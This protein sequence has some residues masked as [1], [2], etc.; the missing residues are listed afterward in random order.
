MLFI[1]WREFVCYFFLT[2]FACFSSLLVC[3]DLFSIAELRVVGRSSFHSIWQRY[4]PFILTTRPR[5]DL[6]WTC[7]QNNRR[8]YQGA[9]ITDAAKQEKLNN[10]LE[11]LPVV[12]LERELYQQMVKD[13]KETKLHDETLAPHKP[14]SRPGR[15]HY[16][17]DY[18]QQ[19]HIHFKIIL[20]GATSQLYS[21]YDR[22][23]TAGWRPVSGG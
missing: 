11:H 18:A 15:V 10:Q 21:C 16:S 5:T 8:I 1:G 20:L 12:T 4:C 19:V 9:N 22:F 2:F 6:C 17:F 13:G 3:N 14:C 7:Q 23:L